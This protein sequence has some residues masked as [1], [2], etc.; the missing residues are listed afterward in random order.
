VLVVRRAPEGDYRQALAAVDLGP[1]SQAVLRA[2]LVV[3]GQARVTA[4]HAY[5]APFEAKLRHKGFPEEDIAR[6]A[7]REGE[8]AHRNMQALLGDPELAGLNLESRIVH[9]HPNPMLPETAHSLGADLVVAG[10]HGG[11]RLE[12]AMMGS[13]TKFLVYY[14]PCDVLV[15]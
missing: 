6:Y 1:R 10:R 7:E 8:A 11:S 5:Q 15:V 3:A 9:G 12:E 14:A 13:I 2:A 4:V